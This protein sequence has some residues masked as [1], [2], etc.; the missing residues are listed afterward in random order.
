[1]HSAQQ[2]GDYYKMGHDIGD[3]LNLLILDGEALDAFDQQCVADHV[4]IIIQTIEDS[5]SKITAG[6]TMGGLTGFMEAGRVAITTVTDCRTNQTEA[7]I[8]RD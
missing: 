3:I 7:A 1:M 5:I 8:V 2:A 4:T 6:D